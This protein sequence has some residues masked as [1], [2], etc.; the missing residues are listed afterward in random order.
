MTSE[1]QT[2]FNSFTSGKNATE[3]TVE[4]AFI[5]GF[6]SR[7]STVDSLTNSLKLADAT[8]STL[9]A[10]IS[11]KAPAKQKGPAYY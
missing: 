7:Q 6:N 2:A 3:L 10:K 9:T 5:A 4:A 8:V 1:Q 11:P